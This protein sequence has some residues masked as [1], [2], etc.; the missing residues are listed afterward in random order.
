M[1]HSTNLLV[2]I[3]PSDTD[4]HLVREAAVHAA[5]T[6]AGLVVLSVMSEAD[7]RARARAVNDIRQLNFEYT[8]DHAVEASRHVALRIATA[9]LTD[10]DVPFEAVGAIGKP[11]EAALK[12]A[13]EYDCN[14]VLVAGHRRRIWDRIRGLP[15]LETAIERVFPG[16]VT[17]FFDHL[18][19]ASPAPPDLTNPSIPHKPT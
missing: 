7:Y 17:V 1:T 14:H 6:G 10:T 5:G 3:D 9:V 19:D 18:H 12:A 15:D 4:G 8:Y 16:N 13:R 11:E 2:I